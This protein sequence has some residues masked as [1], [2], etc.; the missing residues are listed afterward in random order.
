[1]SD[2]AP[3]P[4]PAELELGKAQ[5]LQLLKARVAQVMA[6]QVTEGRLSLSSP[7]DYRAGWAAGVLARILGIPAELRGQWMAQPEVEA[8]GFA[9]AR[10]HEAGMLERA[11]E[12]GPWE[13]CER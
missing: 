5:V 3:M 6:D 8:L 1:M 9:L 12:V 13:G 4:T 7:L 2:R 10:F 11:L